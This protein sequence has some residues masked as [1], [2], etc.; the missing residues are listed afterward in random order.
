MKLNTDACRTCL[1]DSVGGGSCD[2]ARERWGSEGRVVSIIVE[3]DGA[4][5]CALQQSKA[6]PS[7][8]LIP[9]GLRAGRRDLIN[10]RRPE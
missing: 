9:V 4:C 8:T 2:G 7:A 3:Q 5:T 1:L 10:P 6:S